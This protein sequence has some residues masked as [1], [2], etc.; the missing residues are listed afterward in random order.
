MSCLK[1]N[2][3]VKEEIIKLVEFTI[4]DW[5]ENCPK[6]SSWEG[7][8]YLIQKCIESCIRCYRYSGTFIGYLFK[9]LQYAGRGLISTYS[10]HDYLK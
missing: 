6:L 7:H 5:I 9:T 2:V 10:M 3:I 8:E 4:Y 1:G